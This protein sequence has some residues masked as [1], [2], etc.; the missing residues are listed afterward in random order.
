MVQARAVTKLREAKPGKGRKKSRLRWM[1]D[2]ES[3]LRNI[4]V[5]DE[6]Q[7]LC[8]KQGEHLS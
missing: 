3:D 6:E 5:K 1:N 8:T 4:S 2:V 7:E